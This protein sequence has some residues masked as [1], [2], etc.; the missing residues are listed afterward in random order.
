MQL[1]LLPALLRVVPQKAVLVIAMCAS[2]S[3]TALLAAAPYVSRFTAYAA[4]AVGAV[5]SMAFPVISAIKS[6][7]AH[8]SEQGKVQGA[9][10][11]VR[12]LASGLGPVAFSAIFQYYAD[13]KRSFP[14]APFV[15]FTLLMAVGTAVALSLSQSPPARTLAPWDLVERGVHLVMTKRASP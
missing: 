1:L 11:G 13:P 12:S 3:E 8:E 10:Y 6:V 9:L 4:I 5:G 2:T 15:G 14:S 7:N